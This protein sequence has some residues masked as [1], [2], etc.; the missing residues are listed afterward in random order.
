MTYFDE[1]TIVSDNFSN[2]KPAAK[3]KQNVN[4]STYH[5]TYYG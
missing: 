5:E 1:A 4:Q 3:K 2:Q